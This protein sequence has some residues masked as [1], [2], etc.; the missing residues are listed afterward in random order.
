MLSPMKYA[1]HFTGRGKNGEKEVEGRA[2]RVEV[3]VDPA[4]PECSEIGE[5][6]GGGAQ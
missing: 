4:K 5:E 3:G 1:S 2:S 6:Q